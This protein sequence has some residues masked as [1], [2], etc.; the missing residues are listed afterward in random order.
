MNHFLV[1][2]VFQMYEILHLSTLYIYQVYYYYTDIKFV[3]D[4]NLVLKECRESNT[5]SRKF[6]NKHSHSR[7]CF[8]KVSIV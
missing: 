2:Q 4:L 8:R 6:T 3:L 5:T 7:D 1:Q